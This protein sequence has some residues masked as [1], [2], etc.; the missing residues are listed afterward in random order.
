MVINLFYT[1]N[2]LTYLITFSFFKMIMALSYLTADHLGFS[3]R[4]I[5]IKKKS[6]CQ[7]KLDN[8]CWRSSSTYLHISLILLGY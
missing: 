2:A 5:K 7:T 4:S 6:Q 8:L 3:Y 1:T